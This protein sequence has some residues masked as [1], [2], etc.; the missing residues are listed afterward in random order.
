[1]NRKL[2]FKFIDLGSEN[3]RMQPFLTRF[4][5]KNERNPIVFRVSGATRRVI[6]VFV[7]LTSESKQKQEESNGVRMFLTH[8]SGRAE[9]K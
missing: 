3:M 4:G 1:M 7:V 2:A 8:K 5:S 9:S 6:A